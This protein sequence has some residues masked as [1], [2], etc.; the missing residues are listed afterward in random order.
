MQF[1]DL[2]AQQERIRPALDRRLA[3]VLRHG[4][5]IMGPEVAELETQLASLC[6]TAHC[7][8]CANGTDALQMAMMALGLQPGQAVLTTPFTFMATAECIALLGAV[9]V[10]VD[11]DPETFNLDPRALAE[12]IARLQAGDLPG[13]AG[14]AL[15]AAPEAVGVIPVDLYG[16]PADYDAI[17]KIAAQHGL[18]VIED[19]AQSVGA[20]YHGRPTGSLATVGT[21]SFF[22]AKPLGCYG[23]GGA[24]LTDDEELADVLRSLRVHG[25]GTHKYDN[26]RLGLNS[27]LDTLQAAIVL[28]KLEVFA[29]E[30]ERRQTVAAC[31]TELL[32][33]RLHPAVVPEGLLSAWAQ[34]AIRHPERDRLAAAL[35]DADIPSAV[36]YPRPLHL[37]PV[38]GELGYRAGDFPVSEK[39]AQEV[40][41]LPMHPYLER[42][43]Q[44]R[45]ADVL[46]DTIESPGS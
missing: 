26:V 14:K 4:R 25:K 13:R 46:N 31:Y 15:E 28:A 17:N 16:L 44:Q 37:Q 18:W 27:R 38:Y 5:Y 32:D 41:C 34:F 6:G 19:G 7:V 22:P 9:P 11:I 36:Y 29:E 10:F 43:D 30:I 35:R 40:L 2:A 20:R 23:D 12:Q 39:L 8:S 3:E 1:I 45:V 24:L 21:A 33:E 42:D